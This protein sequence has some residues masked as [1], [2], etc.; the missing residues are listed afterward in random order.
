[1]R[2][3]LSITGS[4][5]LPATSPARTPAAVSGRGAPARRAPAG[6][7]RRDTTLGELEPAGGAAHEVL[8]QHAGRQ[9]GEDRAQLGDRPVLALGAARRPHAPGSAR[10][11]RRRTAPTPRRESAAPRRP[12]ARSDRRDRAPRGAARRGARASA[13]PP[14]GPPAASRPDPHGRRRGT[15]RARARFAAAHRTCSSV[16][17]VPMIPTALRSPAW[18]SAST[19][20]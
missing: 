16:S 12:R 3:L 19:S 13:R 6:E 14:A 17:A 1:M 10:P 18:W 8:A 9:L 7:Q 11:R 2:T 5:R 15:A 20:V 4:A